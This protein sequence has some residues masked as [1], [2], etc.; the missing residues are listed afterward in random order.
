MNCFPEHLVSLDTDQPLWDRFF[1]I[2]PLVVVG[3]REPDG[4]ENLAPK[5][6][7]M[8]MGWSNLFGFICTP[9]HATY[10]NI[11]RTESFSVSFPRATQ[12]VMASL[13]AEPR[14]NE[15]DKPSIS[16]LPTIPSLQVDGSFL[17]DG[18]LFFECSLERIIDGFGGNSLIV[19]NI[20]GAYA[21]EKALRISE[22]EDEEV[23]GDS[24]ILAYVSPG[25][26]CSIKDSSYFPFP[27]GF[28]KQ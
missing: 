6:M 3:T 7:A 13:A 17:R 24:K 18:Y 27:S 22:K 14:S 25:R 26:Y 28:K 4:K 2:A 9:T 23:V 15:G 8:P 19:G 1:M 21:D 10:K 16:L 20:I 11:I 12:V 5:H